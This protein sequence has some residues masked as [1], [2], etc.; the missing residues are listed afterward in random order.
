MEKDIL[1]YLPTVMFRGTPGSLIGT[2]SAYCW[3]L[4]Q[5]GHSLHSPDQLL[6]SRIPTNTSVTVY[7]TSAAAEEQKNE[8]FYFMRHY[9]C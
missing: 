1:N 6:A 9:V 5:G 2:A 4:S 8:V 7:L 3:V